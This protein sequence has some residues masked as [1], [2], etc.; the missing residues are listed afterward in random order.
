MTSVMVYVVG[1]ELSTKGKIIDESDE[2]YN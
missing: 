2:F 1:E